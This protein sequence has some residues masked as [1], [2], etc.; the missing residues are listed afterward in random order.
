M[1][2]LQNSIHPF[3]FC[4]VKFALAIPPHTDPTSRPLPGRHIVNWNCPRVS[5]AD[6][7]FQAL[8]RSRGPKV[9]IFR[10]LFNESY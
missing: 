7:D 1:S 2:N 5:K 3:F 4:F 9:S 6:P 10:R 8:N